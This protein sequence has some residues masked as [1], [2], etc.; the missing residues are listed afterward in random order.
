MELG[1]GKEEGGACEARGLFLPLHAGRAGGDFAGAPGDG[2]RTAPDQLCRLGQS[3]GAV[4]AL[5]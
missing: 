1:D 4:G 3:G 2:I 5:L